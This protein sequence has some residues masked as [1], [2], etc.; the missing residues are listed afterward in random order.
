MCQIQKRVDLKKFLCMDCKVDIMDVNGI[1]HYYSLRNEIW[2]RIC[3]GKEKAGMLCLFCVEKRL[4]RKLR[5]SDFSDAP[6]NFEEDKRN[7]I[8]SFCKK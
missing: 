7:L 6:L 5:F 1:V 3:L 8:K 4:G 2:N